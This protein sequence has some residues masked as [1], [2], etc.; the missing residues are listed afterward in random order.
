[1]RG[2]KE[3][4]ALQKWYV[5]LKKDKLQKNKNKFSIKCKKKEIS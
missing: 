5:R 1:M 2:E 3:I 4:W